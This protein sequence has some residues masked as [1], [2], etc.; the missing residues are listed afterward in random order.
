MHGIICL[1]GKAIILAE[2]ILA[3][4]TQLARVLIEFPERQ[5]VISDSGVLSRMTGK[6]LFFFFS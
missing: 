6:T 3:K 4:R 1:W 5:R 2:R